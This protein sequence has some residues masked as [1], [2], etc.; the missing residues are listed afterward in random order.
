[1]PA[2]FIQTGGFNAP[3]MPNI[4]FA[5]PR[6]FATNMAL[7]NGIGQGVNTA[8]ALQQ[9][10]QSAA[11]APITQKL[12]QEQIQRQQQLNQMLPIEQQQQQINLNKA[13]MPVPIVTGTSPVS[14]NRDTGQPITN[15][16]DYPANTPVDV[17]EMNS[18]F[19]VNPVTG[20]KTPFQ[21]PGKVLETDEQRQ[22]R[23]SLQKYR[24][25]WNTARQTSATGSLIGKGRL[26]VTG[27]DGN[28]YNMVPALDDDGNITYKM[29]GQDAK[30]TIA[31]QNADTGAVIGAAKASDLSSLNNEHNAKAEQ[32]RSTNVKPKE[33]DV[34]TDKVAKSLG[35]T[36]DVYNNLRNSYE[37]SKALRLLSSKNVNPNDIDDAT[38]STIKKAYQDVEAAR[39]KQMMDAQA[40][41]E[42]PKVTV[43]GLSGSQSPQ[44]NM[45]PVNTQ[46]V[47]GQPVQNN[48]VQPQQT[49]SVPQQNKQPGVMRTTT[50]IQVTPQQ[51]I[52]AIQR[53]VANPKLAPDFDQMFGP[54]ASARALTQ[55]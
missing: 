2:S 55:R 47:Q 49:Q 4:E 1:M 20:E 21:R 8:G 29:V 22:L 48:N 43:Q 23:E 34:E 27:P 17:V 9:Q 51:Y 3:V 10:R 5:D 40:L 28:P 11:M 6:L 26:T 50:G 38:E 53:L 35:L 37:G 19:L 32:I 7:A 54:G 46:P 42:G 52:A 33:T 45:Q 36:G 24:A 44:V 30:T 39:A 14:I 16:M 15:D 12:G 13:S 25:G 18:G 41:A 31:K